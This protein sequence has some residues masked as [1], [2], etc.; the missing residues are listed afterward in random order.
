[1]DY[2]ATA[3][4]LCASGDTLRA[5]S[6]LETALREGGD[7][8]QVHLA[9]ASV[10]LQAGDWQAGLEQLEQLRADAGYQ[11]TIEA[12][13]GGALL[14]LNRI[15]DAKDTLDTAFERSPENFYVLLKRGELYCRMGIYS[16]AVDALQRAQK[17]GTDDPIIREAVRRL[18][19]FARTKDNEGFVRNVPP[20]FS[21]YRRLVSCRTALATIVPNR[22]L[23]TVKEER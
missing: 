19:R 17:V 11:P 21:L 15:T 13:I 10:L 5:Q 2:L 12:Y 8:P 3:R 22:R 1:M 20:R 23:R 7:D 18:L 9:Y 16:V 6:T 4:Q 14:G